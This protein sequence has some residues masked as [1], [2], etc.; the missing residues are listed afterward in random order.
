M[1]DKGKGIPEVPTKINDNTKII[2]ISVMCV[3]GAVFL[4]Y[5]NAAS[6]KK[7]TKSYSSEESA[8]VL[9]FVEGKDPVFGS[10]INNKNKNDSSQKNDYIEMAQKVVEKPKS[11]NNESVDPKDLIEFKKM[12]DSINEKQM[13]E[14]IQRR[15]AKTLVYTNNYSNSVKTG[16]ASFKPKSFKEEV[17]KTTPKVSAT[18]TA[19]LS[20]S[21]LEG[22]IIHATL[23]TAVN[24]DLP[25]S[26]RAI[27][28][29]PVY[30][31]DG[32][33][34]L[35]NPGDRLVMKYT[36]KVTKGATRVFAVG[37]RIIKSDGISINLGSEVAS[38]LGVVGLGAD[39]VDT[40]FFEKFAEASLLA[41]LSA[42]AATMNVS[43]NEQYN[44][45][46]MYRSGVADSFA[47][48]ARSSLQQ[49]TNLAPTLRIG[50]GREITV[51]VAKDINFD[52]VYGDLI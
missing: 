6:S 14:I 16:D 10:R 15:S 11:E 20:T 21:I 18:R 19:N 26:M 43:D 33:N 40:H 37:S 50:Q 36:S 47:D 27:I 48:A 3:L 46:S 52:D 1:S 8:P 44:S 4:L 31:A 28:N 2:A 17:D 5:A 35:L 42:G 7:M 34:K 45:L 32:L 49:N 23:E 39:S 41:V 29:R 24:S 13:R 12:M 22:T 9:S 38:Q 30:S 25:G 51:F